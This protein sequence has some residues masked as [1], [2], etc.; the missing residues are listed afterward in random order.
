MVVAIYKKKLYQKSSLL[1]EERHRSA[2]PQPFS[3]HEK[4]ERLRQKAKALR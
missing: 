1:L 2:R 3:F 4:R